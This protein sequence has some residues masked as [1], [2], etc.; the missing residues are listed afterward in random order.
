[1]DKKRFKILSIDGGGIRGIFP[2]MF[3]ANVEAE[4]QARGYKN[5]QIHQHFDLICGTSTGGILA[6][7]LALGIPAIKIHELY[8]KN[9]PQIF[10][11]KRGL[12]KTVLRPS[13]ER[14]NL[15]AILKE[16][17]TTYNNG[18]EP[19]LADCRTNVCIPIYDLL[20]GK[21]SVCKNNY[22]PKFTRDYHIPAY[23]VALATSAAP[24]YFN[25]YSAT[26]IDLN[27]IEK[28]F[29]NKV[30]GGVMANNPTLAGIIEAQ[31]AFYQ[32]LSNLNVLSI[33]TGYQKFTDGNDLLKCGLKYW[34]FPKRRIIELF[35]QG[36]SQQ[37]EN[38][39]SLLQNGID[40]EKK[41]I[42]EFVYKRINTE[43]DDTSNV[44]MDETNKGKLT[45]LAE[46]ATFEFSTHASEIIQTFFN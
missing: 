6:I 15:E 36:Q 3:L 1:M 30:D 37:V 25:P 8:M 5:W 13:Y 14:T 9:A 33:G 18:K 10:G 43:F 42:P 24:T 38:L 4:L 44:E 23:Q 27:G 12:F 34:L 35:M 32:P 40:S 16:T 45:K 26:Y 39:I 20:H 17:F 2:A 21:P 22:H 28:T 29:S 41:H 7:A 46:K 31:A 19:R 11:N